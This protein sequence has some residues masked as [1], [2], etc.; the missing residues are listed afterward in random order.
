MAMPL[1]P[2]VV[3]EFLSLRGIFRQANTAMRGLQHF[4]RLLGHQQVCNL[5]EQP[6]CV[7]RLP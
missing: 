2:N 3:G 4:Q 1:T 6:S 7:K 5:P